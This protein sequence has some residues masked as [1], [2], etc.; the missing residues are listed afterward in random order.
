MQGQG[1]PLLCCAK[2]A[3]QVT[4]FRFLRFV[5][6]GRAAGHQSGARVRARAS[7]ARGRDPETEKMVKRLTT[8]RSARAW[9]GDRRSKEMDHMPKVSK[10]SAK[11]EDYGPVESWHEE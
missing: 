2:E 9:T 7:V 3:L 6:S 8:G 10:E 4:A 5:R 11:H 1:G